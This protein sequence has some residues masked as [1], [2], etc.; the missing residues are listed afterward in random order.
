MSAIETKRCY[1]CGETKPVTAFGSDRSR[2]DGRNNRC[3]TCHNAY[4]A[5]H[6]RTPAGKRAN[7]AR[8]RGYREGADVILRQARAGGCAICGE[9][10]EACLAFHHLDP[11]TKRL[12]PKWLRTRSPVAITPR[13][14]EM[15]IQDLL[16]CAVLCH[17]CHAK[18]HAGR[19]PGLELK[20]ISFE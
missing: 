16:G 2:K 6:N 5:E 8:K 3:Q 7:A 13:L 1:K 10:D 11:A 15:I 14:H 9:R 12:R 20:P 18:F 4:H 17:N 19:F